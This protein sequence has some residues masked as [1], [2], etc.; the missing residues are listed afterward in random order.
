MPE[1]LWAEFTESY[2]NTLKWRQTHWMGRRMSKLPGDLI[3]LQEIMHTVRPDWI[4]HTGT[5]N[6]GLDHYLAS[7]CDLLDHGQIV[8]I[9]RKLADDLPEHPR[10]TYVEG[11]AHLTSTRG[12]VVAITGPSPHAM[13]ILGNKASS[14][15]T[16]AEY[17]NYEDLVSQGSYLV[18]ED[19]VVGGHPVWP[20]FGVGPFEAVKGVTETRGDFISDT[21]LEKYGL[22]F[23]PTGYMKRVRET[24]RG[25]FRRKKK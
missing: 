16:S 21:S 13:V 15:R 4:V 6:G 7:I 17:H 22:T 11:E 8:S 23:N 2:Y 1:D 19:T 5:A 12:K 18:M 3:I 25:I 10:I 20:N 9:D 14:A 24:P